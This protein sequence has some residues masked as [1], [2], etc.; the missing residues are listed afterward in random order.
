M[1]RRQL[2]QYASAS[3]IGTLGLGLVS[4]YQTLQAQSGS[5]TITSLGHTAF[6]FTG[7]GQRILVNPFK[8]AGCTAGYAEPTASADLILLSSRLFDEGFLTNQYANT[9]V[10]ENPGDYTINGLT[11][12]G[13]SMP[14]DRLGG[15][16]FGTNNAWVW[17]QAGVKVVHL[18]G[19]AA[20][21][22]LEHKILLG[23]PDILLVPVG[24]GPKAYTPEEAAEAI[25]ELTPKVVIPT[26][27]RTEAADANCDLVGVGDFISLMSGTPVTQGDNTLSISADSLPSSGM[28]IEVLGYAF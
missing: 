25:R 28:R 18:G 26:H 15:R 4:S 8:A 14:H 1:K 6:L 13:V 5:L 9:Q 27:Y 7:G 3:F 16:R 10:L 21:L 19:A 17:S 23:R 20:P 22:S 12:R 11:V 2:L 24:G